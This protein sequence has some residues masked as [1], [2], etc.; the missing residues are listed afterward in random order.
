MK[1][2]H[3]IQLK[4]HTK[5]VFRSLSD[6]AILYKGTVMHDLSNGYMVEAKRPINKFYT[7]MIYVDQSG[8]NDSL[9]V[10]IQPLDH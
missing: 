9:N 4:P 2:N 7:S 5:V 10:Y 8:K 3:T 1:K 6:D